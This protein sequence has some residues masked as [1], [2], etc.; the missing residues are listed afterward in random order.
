MLHCFI[1]PCPSFQFILNHYVSEIFCLQVKVIK[2]VYFIG[3][4]SELFSNRGHQQS[5]EGK[6]NTKDHLQRII[7]SYSH[8]G[9]KNSPPQQKPLCNCHFHF[10]SNCITQHYF[11]GYKILASLSAL[12]FF[13]TAQ[14]S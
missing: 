8:P 5:S 1:G 13:N 2:T 10:S 14:K 3:P 6:H 7:L 12:C 11:D 4:W 9:N